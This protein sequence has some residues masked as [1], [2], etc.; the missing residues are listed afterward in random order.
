MQ[1]YQVQFRAVAF[2]LAEAILRETRAE[3]PHNRVPRDLR[4]HARGGD[5]EAVAITVDDRRLRERERKY[6]QAIDQDMLRLQRQGF[7]RHPHGLMRRAQDVDRVDLDRIDNPD[8][9]GDG[10]V[11]D[12]IV[13]DLLALFLKE[14]LRI[15]QLPVPEFLREDDR[16]G[17]DWTGERP[18][19]SLINSRDGR[20][21]E[22]PEFAFMPKTAAPVHARK[23]LKS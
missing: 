6:R 19:P 16:G 13:V 22:R 3:V 15:V 18:A 5:G 23:I 1:F 9:P 21:A 20:D 10:V 17:D 4:D 7:D 12:E 11:R 14:L 2:V 8:C